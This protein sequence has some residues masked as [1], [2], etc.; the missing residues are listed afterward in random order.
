MLRGAEKGRVCEAR[1]PFF[2]QPGP[3]VSDS[4]IQEQVII[5]RGCLPRL[6]LHKDGRTAS[7]GTA[8]VQLSMNMQWRGRCRSELGEGAASCSS[9]E[10]CPSVSVVLHPKKLNSTTR[11]H[12]KTCPS[13]GCIF[14]HAME[15]WIS[16][17]RHGTSKLE[18]VSFIQQIL[19]TA[20]KPDTSHP[21]LRWSLC[22]RL[23]IWI[24]G[25]P[26]K[27]MSPRLFPPHVSPD[28]TVVGAAVAMTWFA[29]QRMFSTA[30]HPRFHGIHGIFLQW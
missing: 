15:S 20:S 22:T 4:T 10:T 9:A 5:L 25:S 11:P 16:T 3:D 28:H 17:S 6:D 14:S 2:P 12:P 18:Q 29:A 19:R 21:R 26:G 24:H 8:G 13:P 1:A 7:N 27:D 23:H 30:W